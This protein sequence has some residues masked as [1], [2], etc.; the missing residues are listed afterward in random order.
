MNAFYLRPFLFSQATLLIRHVMEDPQTLTQT[1]EK[2]IR[3]STINTNASNTKELHYLLR[4]LA[5]AA[6][7]SPDLFA[8]VSRD[9]LRVDF[10]LLKKSLDLDEDKR[11]I[12]K[13]L[14]AKNAQITSPLND[15]S[16]SVICDLL[17]FLVRV[18]PP[19]KQTSQDHFMIK[20]KKESIG[21]NVNHFSPV[22]F[23]KLQPKSLRPTCPTMY[24]PRS[25]LFD[26][27]PE[28]VPALIE[29]K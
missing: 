14:P 15:V 13:S 26:L 8:D 28:P 17:N 25:L 24:H 5:P 22:F 6:C 19:G 29:P 12:L 1:M 21:R 7:R 20:K 27:A 11:L 10:N 4:M 9:I 23:Q 18:P 2:V 3:S 16:R